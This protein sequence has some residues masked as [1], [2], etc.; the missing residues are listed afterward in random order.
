MMAYDTVSLTTV[1]VVV[2]YIF[3]YSTGF[4]IGKQ[5]LLTSFFA[6]LRLKSVSSS[7]GRNLNILIV[8]TI[9]LSFCCVVCL[10]MKMRGMSERYGI[11]LSLKGAG[12]IRMVNT[13]DV[14]YE[15]GSSIYGILASMLFGFP[16]LAG[17]IALSYKNCVSLIQKR[18]LWVTFVVG[19]S[20]SFLSGGRFMALTFATF[21]FFGAKILN[22]KDRKK[23]LSFK[24]IMIGIAGLFLLWLFVQMFL[25]RV[26]VRRISFAIYMLPMCYPKSFTIHLLNTFPATDTLIS[27][28]SYFEYYIAHGVNQLDVLLNAPFPKGAPYWGGYEL[29]TFF[30]FLKKIGLPVITIDEIVKEI[31]NPGVYFTHIGA[32]YL[33]FGFW[34]SIFVVFIFGYFSGSLWIR[35]SWNKPKLSLIYLN[36]IILSLVTFA[37]IISMIS[38]GYFASILVSYAVLIIFENIAPLSPLN[39][40]KWKGEVPKI[41][42]DDSKTVCESFNL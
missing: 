11:D 33:D 19:L 31:V 27:V 42:N 39:S 9:I 15:L 2:A 34:T 41:M 36:V 4:L 25:D 12:Q 3:L 24:K 5:Y 18:T 21:Y 22:T 40:I 6:K 37:P 30:I 23:S 20:A 38:A 35:L 16:V 7:Y 14:S 29:S 28:F 26:G 8:L 13:G 17:M 32:L 10:I 1:V